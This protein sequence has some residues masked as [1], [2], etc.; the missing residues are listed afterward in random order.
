MYLLNQSDGFPRNGVHMQED[1]SL[2][3]VISSDM[4]VYGL[5]DSGCI[6]L[7]S[8]ISCGYWTYRTAESKL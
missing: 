7:N 1:S 8:I 5:G 2:K 4:A 3:P 6:L